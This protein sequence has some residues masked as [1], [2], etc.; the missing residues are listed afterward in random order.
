MVY[1]DWDDCQ[2]CEEVD[3]I[4]HGERRVCPFRTSSAGPTTDR[5]VTAW[6]M[7]EARRTSATV[8]QV[9]RAVCVDPGDVM[10]LLATYPD[11]VDD[12]WEEDGVLTKAGIDEVHNLLNP[13]CER[14]APEVYPSS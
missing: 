8:D 2:V 5:L 11:D 9:A 4:F 14:T 3:R 1:P 12:L 10:A 6:A 7:G 13:M